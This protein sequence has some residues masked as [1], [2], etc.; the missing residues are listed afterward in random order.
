MYSAFTKEESMLA[1]EL[2]IHSGLPNPRWILLPS[3]EQELLDRTLANPSLVSELTATTSELGYRGFIVRLIKEDEGAWSRAQASAGSQLPMIFRVGGIVENENN[4]SKWLL[5]TADKPNNPITP[6]LRD[7]LRD[8]TTHLIPTTQTGD[9]SATLLGGS[10]RCCAS[11]F[12]PGTNYDF[13]NQ[14]NHVLRNNCYNFAANHRSDTFAQPGQR[15]G[16]LR[17]VPIDAADVARALA[18][19]GWKVG[20]EPR[21][22][23][24]IALVTMAPNIYQPGGDFHFYRLV[25]TGPYTWGHKPGQAPAS[26]TD[27]SGNRISDPQTC[28]RRMRLS[29]GSFIAGYTDFHGYW[30]QDNNDAYVE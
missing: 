14:V 15:G 22:N 18:A 19:D 30:Y 6:S 12:L 10:N 26:D 13:W 23:L 27:T 3:E 9:G 24:N 25:S 2:D 20:C 29:D 28:D 11:S 8:S 4:T 16:R 21:N 1:V 5:D 7:L 17:S